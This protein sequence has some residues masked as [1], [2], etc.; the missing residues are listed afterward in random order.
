MRFYTEKHYLCTI[1]R[2][3]MEKV[4]YTLCLPSRPY[5]AGTADLR[6]AVGKLVD[7]NGCT[8]L[9]CTDGAAWVSLNLKRRKIRKGDFLMLSYE[10]SLILLRVS[11]DFSVRFVSLPPDIADEVYYRIPSDSFWDYWDAFTVSHTSPGQYGLLV[12]WFG[13]MEWIAE[14]ADGEYKAQMIRNNFHN[15]CMAVD[16]EV[17]RLRPTDTDSGK[18]SRG[19]ALFNRFFLLLNRYY[20]RHRDVDFYARKLCITPDYLYKISYK[21]ANVSPKEVIDHQV[22]VAIKTYLLDTSLSVKNI[23]SELNFDDPSYM[24]RFFRRMTA[25]SPMDFRNNNSLKL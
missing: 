11:G 8:L 20:A 1:S 3:L 12:G 4:K 10:M 5:A 7:L 21:V 17:R 6:Q 25:M 19:W 9:L 18:K 24:C 23:A 16:S 13:Q 14:T 2:V 22:L 15:L